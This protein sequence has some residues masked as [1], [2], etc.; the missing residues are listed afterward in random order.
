[1]LRRS[2][3][4]DILVNNA[5]AGIHIAPLDRLG[6]DE[7]AR[8]IAVNLT[9]ALLGCRRAA[10][11][12]RRQKDGII[13]NISSVCA[14][15]AWPG[16]GPY[17][18]AKAGLEQLG[19]VLHAELRPAGV[20]VTTITPSWGATHFGQAAR[21]PAGDPNIEPLKMQP[22]EM[23]ELVRHICELPARLVMPH[24]RIQPMVQEIVPT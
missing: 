2:G 24:V 4:L 13:V 5:G 23:G 15:H 19:K 8:S 22:R 18:A 16:W 17:S 11:I 14:V 9:G 10:R 20:R 7:I 6:D 12:M 1:V 21:L 3:R